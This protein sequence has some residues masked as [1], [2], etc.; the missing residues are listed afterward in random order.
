MIREVAEMYPPQFVDE[1]LRLARADRYWVEVHAG[2]L[3]HSYAAVCKMKTSVR[4]IW[5]NGADAFGFWALSWWLADGPKWFCP[6]EEQCASLEQIEVGVGLGDYAQPY[7]ALM[8]GMPEGRYGPFA[9]A[10]C[11][12]VPGERP[13]LTVSLTSDGHQ[14]DIVTTIGVDGRPI[15]ESLCRFDEDCRQYDGVA[16]RALRV[17]INACLCLASFGTIKEHLHPKR[18]ESDRALAAEQSERGVRAR[19]RLRLATT[20][21]SFRQ[22]VR[23]HREAGAAQS[24]AGGEA[25]GRE[26]SPHW[27]RGH[28]HTVVC[29]RGR[30]G[31]RLKLYSPTMVRPDLFVGDASDTTTTYR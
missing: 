18:V 1:L 28:W 17:A 10:L 16:V 22:D 31:R 6:S 3:S 19:R 4:S 29:G 20:V 27:R 5:K 13:L 2:P 26:M 21:V 24:R 11:H 12:H 8:V 15:E 23:L 7:P 30:T 9:R 25:T 14:D